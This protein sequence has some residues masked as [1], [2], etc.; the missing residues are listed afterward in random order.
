MHFSIIIL[1]FS[2][3]CFIIL[4]GDK[5]MQISKIRH[6]RQ[7]A[8]QFRLIRPK[9]TDEHT[10]FFFR[11][12]VNLELSGVVVPL[13]AGSCI[14]YPPGTA[15]YFT[16]QGP[17]VH[18]WLQASEDITPLI[19]QYHLPVGQPFPAKDPDALGALFLQTEQEFLSR[20]PYREDMLNA[21]LHALLIL[22]ARSAGQF[23]PAAR[24]KQETHLDIKEIRQ[25]VLSNPQQRWTVGEMAKMMSLSPSRFHA[26]YK[27]VFGTAPMRDVIG[28]KIEYAKSLLLS[29]RNFSLPQIADML[30]YNDQYHFIRQF[31]T[32]TGMTPGAY[33]KSHR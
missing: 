8:D 18:S 15:Q 20:N 6:D 17:L 30:S 7:E 11:T 10:L 23:S 1:T 16:A 25:H 2:T 19:L 28:A 5:N 14:L 31:R 27:E 21:F 3:V 26:V 13:P 9:G 4:P 33:R 12:P 24:F 22:L 32:E 29:E